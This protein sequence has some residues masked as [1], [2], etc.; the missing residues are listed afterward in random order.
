MAVIQK[1]RNSGLV[2]VVIISA[3]VL[4]VIGDILSGSNRLGLGNEDQDVAGIIAGKKIREKDVQA[5][6]EEFFNLFRR[7]DQNGELNDPENLKKAV[8]AAW[9]Q[10]WEDIVRLNTTDKAI[11]MAGIDITDDDFNE[12]FLGDN[13]LNEVTQI[14]AFWKDGKYDKETLKSIW[15]RNKKDPTQRQ[16]LED[17][18]LDLKRRERE[19]RYNRYVLKAHKKPKALLKYEYIRANQNTSGK[20]VTL[21]INTVADKDIKVTESDL[22]KYLDEHKEEF[23][24]FEDSRDINYM[25]LEI[26]PSSEDTSYYKSLADAAAKRMAAE[27]KPDTAAGPDVVG[28]INRGSLPKKTPTEVAQLVWPSKVGDVS[29]PF[30]KDG[31]YSVYQ[32]LDEKRDTAPSVNVAHILLTP[33]MTPKGENI[34]DSVEA[35]AKANELAAKIKGGEDIGKLAAEWSVDK[36]SFMNGGS[37]GWVGPDVYN[38]NGADKPGYVTEYKN[39]CLRAK[40]GQVEV[41]KSPLG[42]HVMKALEDPDFLQVKYKFESFEIA[43]GA[44]T[45]KEVD[46]MS[47]KFRNLITDGKPQNFEAACNKVG[48]SMKVQANVKTA[49][50]TING[51]SSLA[52]VRTVYNWLFDKKRKTGDVSDVI[53]TPTRHIVILVS[54]VRK[55]GYAE[56]A[57]V[58]DLIEPLVKNELKAKKLSEK[59]ENALKT[60]KTAE[61]LAQKTNG[62]IIPVEALRMNMGFI[63][64]IQNETKI[65]GALFGCAEKKLS[66]P[67]VGNGVVAVIWVDK[68]DKVDVPASALNTAGFDMNNPEMFK[69]ALKSVAEIQDYRYKFDWNWSREEE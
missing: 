9:A 26:R 18:W 35:L 52:D 43:P 65:I 5:K 29:G 17:F 31:R 49:D 63:P 54:R 27:T 7:R 45:I 4:F 3:L 6:A 59:F 56:V 20:I 21:N 14:E 22:K 15:K 55:V 47:R 51:L 8:E 68:R 32:K 24:Q 34:K 40:K 30:Y 38:G 11:D 2:V 60:A 58:K 41:V 67:V 16:F 33:G 69:N 1:L 28:F 19:N 66:K 44:K 42:F 61:E 64:Q 48:V 62:A 57:D 10:A 36:G 46:Q 13:P 37:Y 25:Y 12:I 23:R 39:F 50:K 53:A